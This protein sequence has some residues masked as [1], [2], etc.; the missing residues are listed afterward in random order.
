MSV[1]KYCKLISLVCRLIPRLYLD[2]YY[3]AFVSFN[4][5]GAALGGLFLPQFWYGHDLI[6]D[7]IGG[8]DLS[9]YISKAEN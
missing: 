9:F 7:S 1:C 3:K 5:R 2:V 4:V 6:L 8:L